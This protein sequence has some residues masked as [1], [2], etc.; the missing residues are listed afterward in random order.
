M[1]T[2]AH[3]LRGANKNLR[4][5][6]AFALDEGRIVARTKGGHVKFLKVGYCPIFTSFTPSDRRAGLNA[7][8]QL[9]AQ[10]MN[11][12]DQTLCPE[13]GPAAP[14]RSPIR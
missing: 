8:A 1:T 6:V 11:E 4:D 3:A 7:R 9:R 5:L 2:P 10:P 14:W 12:L 13:P